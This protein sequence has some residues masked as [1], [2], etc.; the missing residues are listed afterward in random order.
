VIEWVIEGTTA[1]TCLRASEFIMAFLAGRK[2]E[3][4]SPADFRW[5][6]HSTS[7]PFLVD[8][9]DILYVRA[10][11]LGGPGCVEDE[12]ILMDDE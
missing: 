2:A 3:I 12:F 5:E 11:G 8:D 10:E 7:E 6:Y 1:L 4:Y 9:G